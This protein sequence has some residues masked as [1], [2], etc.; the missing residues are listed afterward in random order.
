MLDRKWMLE[1]EAKRDAA[2]REWQSQQAERDHQWRVQQDERDRAW[3]EQESA[4]AD[5]RE[6]DRDVTAREWRKEDRFT[7]KTTMFLSVLLGLLGG[8]ISLIAANK[9]GWYEGIT[10]KPDSSPVSQIR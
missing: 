4:K 1:Q 6:K 3:R 8:L 5:A 7:A 2:A 9:L 10:P